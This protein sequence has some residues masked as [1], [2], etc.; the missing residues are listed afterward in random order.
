MSGRG[1]PRAVG[2][3]EPPGRKGRKEQ[4]DEKHEDEDEEFAGSELLKA[5]PF[6]AF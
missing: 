4:E 5:H 1:A 2:E 3:K 6:S